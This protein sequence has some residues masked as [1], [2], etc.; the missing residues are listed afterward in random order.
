MKLNT[1]WFTVTAVI[2]GTVPALILYIWCSINGF[3]AELV[4]LFESVHPSGGFS[5]VA[6]LNEPPAS[7][8]AGVIIN[9]LYTLVDFF[10][11]GIAFSGLY[12]FLVTKFD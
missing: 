5:I 2:V 3:G 6:N 4:S 7:R 1:K 8:I 12:N 9:T 10:I 11:L